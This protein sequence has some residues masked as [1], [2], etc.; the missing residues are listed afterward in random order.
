MYL[1]Q[2]LI[3]CTPAGRH[4]EQHD[5]FFCIAD[6][7]ADCIPQ[8]QLFWPEVAQTMHVDG[9]RKVQSVN[10]QSVQIV[11]KN[12]KTKSKGQLFFINLGGYKLGEFEEF[13]YKMVIAAATKA[14]AIKQ[15]KATAFY[16]HT[17]FKGA[18]SHIDDKYGI[19]VDDVHAIADILPIAAQ[20]NYKIVLQDGAQDAAD[21]IN[22]G[23]FQLKK[24]E[25][26]KG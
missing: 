3:G 18:E 21:E 11:P 26:M 6:S 20:E 10:G 22:L 25:K 1:Y 19:D 4:I 12:S 5:M 7:I 2:I 17:G 23:Y 15:A 16:K 8:M 9:F 13:H 14:D 24:L